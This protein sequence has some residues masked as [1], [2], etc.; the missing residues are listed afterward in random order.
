[1]NK[2][3]ITTIGL[4][5]F[6]GS[7][8][9]TSLPSPSELVLNIS[10]ALAQEAEDA[11]DAAAE[12]KSPWTGSF[13]L[14]F[15]ASKTTTNTIGLNANGALTRTDEM[16]TW[17]SS[18]KYVYNYDDSE[19]KDNFF[20]A[21]SDYDRLFDI[22]SPWSWFLNGS[23]QFNST[24]NYR[25]RVKGFAGLG[26]FFSRTEELSWKARGGAGTTWDQR[27]TRSGWTPRA[28]LSTG[29]TWKPVEGMTFEG[30]ASYEPDFADFNN[31]LAVLEMKVNLAIS[32][33]DNVSIYFT[34][35]DEYNSKPSQGDSYN[36]IWVTLGFAYGF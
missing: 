10:P 36:Q 33:M 27:G 25:Q 26:Y 22:G 2:I 17:A 9:G 32:S 11:P 15:T 1:M 20:I 16:S 28:M 14:G 30:S 4:L 3:T 35:R 29:A 31:Y 12:E 24:E 34:L 6:A 21:Q 18:I 23:Y 13:G 8:A 7:A 5:A 19:V